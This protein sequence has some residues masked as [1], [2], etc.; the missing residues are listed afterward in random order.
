MSSDR[1]SKQDIDVLRA[2]ETLE[3]DLENYPNIEKWRKRLEQTS[4]QDRER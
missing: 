3:C 2:I 1:P 4:Q